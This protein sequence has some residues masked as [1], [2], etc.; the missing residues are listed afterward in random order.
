MKACLNTLC[1]A[2]RDEPTPIILETMLLN[3]RVQAKLVTTLLILCRNPHVGL[4]TS[5]SVF[6]VPN[7]DP[8]NFTL[9][10]VVLMNILK[11][12]EGMFK[13]SYYHDR[14]MLKEKLSYEGICGTRL[15]RLSQYNQEEDG[16][17]PYP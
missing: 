16:Y 10:Y 1:W 12:F 9:N 15:E 4:L 17:Y 11:V 5:D 3:K 6:F 14:R 8:P 7:I 13:A 2:F